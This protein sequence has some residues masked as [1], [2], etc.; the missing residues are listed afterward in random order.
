MLRA[1]AHHHTSSTS[2]TCST[3]SILPSTM[4][5]SGPSSPHHVPGPATLQA[6]SLRAARLLQQHSKH[7]SQGVASTQHTLQQQQQQPMMQL[8]AARSTLHVLLQQPTL[9]LSHA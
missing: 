5:G 3:A 1:H 6:T 9:M 8:Q 2:H 7:H 4:K